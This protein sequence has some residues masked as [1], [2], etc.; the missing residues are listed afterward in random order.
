MLSA[1][2]GSVLVLAGEGLSRGVDEAFLVQ[3]QLLFAMETV[4]GG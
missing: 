4:R 2:V 3:D 1:L